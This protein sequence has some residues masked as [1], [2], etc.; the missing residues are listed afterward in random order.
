[1]TQGYIPPT[2]AEMNRGIMPRGCPPTLKQIREGAELPNKPYTLK[3]KY[4]MKKYKTDLRTARMFEK[5]DNKQKKE[6]ASQLLL[7]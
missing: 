1:M 3:E 6:M 7:G 2:R 5:E 4:L